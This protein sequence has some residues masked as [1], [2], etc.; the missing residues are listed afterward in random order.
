MRQ[1]LASKWEAE[2]SASSKKR[3]FGVG[4]NDATYETQTK[5]GGVKWI[6][7]FYLRWS[8][9]LERC[10]SKSYKDKHPT[11][12][13][14]TVCQEWHT[15]SVFKSWMETQDWEGKQL[16]KDLLVQGN[17]IY[18]P[19]TC[20]FISTTVNGFMVKSNSSRGEFPIGVSLCRRTL[21]YKATIGNLGKRFEAPRL[22]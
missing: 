9:L 6:C 10:Y 16:D 2:L 12:R 18:S 19:E 13:D 15:F 4:L 21:K 3:L 14:V 7:P 8:K 11:Y 22:P 17:S 20:C 5:G 1:L